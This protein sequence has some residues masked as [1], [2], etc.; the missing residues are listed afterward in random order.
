M[1]QPSVRQNLLQYLTPWLH[2]MELVDPNIIPN[3]LMEN[4]I[5]SKDLTQELPKKPLKGR[6][7]GSHE[8]TNM[9]LNNLFYITLMVCI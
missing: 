8:A 9:I 3:N 1:A 2:N 5:I 6:G 7:W 4:L